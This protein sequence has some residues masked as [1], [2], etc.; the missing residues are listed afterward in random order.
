MSTLT[1]DDL[2]RL[3]TTELREVY[4]NGKVGSIEALSGEPVGRMLAIR[5]LLGHRPFSTVIRR[6]SRASAFPW[7]GK[8]FRSVDSDHGNGGNRVTILAWTMEMYRFETSVQDSAL[9]GKPCIVLD[10]A[11]PGNPSFIRAVHDEL[12]EVSPG[13]FL[14][15][16]MIKGRHNPHLALFFAVDTR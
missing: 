11:Q 10:Y 15:P 2:H 8:T 6:I 13:L 1:L 14:G 16:A 9:D 4:R 12:R 5:G 7:R 3:N